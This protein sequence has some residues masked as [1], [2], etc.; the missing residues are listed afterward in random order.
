MI[1]VEHESIGQ[2]D[3]WYTP[4]YVFDALG[5]W[6]DTDVASPGA[7]IVPYIPAVIHIT[8]NSLDKNWFGRVWMNPPFGGQGAYQD[9]AEKFIE[10]GR[11]VA[12]CPSRTGTKWFVNFVSKADGVLFWSPRIKYYNPSKPNASSPGFASVLVAKGEQ[13]TRALKKL[14][15][16]HG[17]FFTPL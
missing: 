4:K 16:E 6:F 8:E 14:N 5:L 15:G 9:W 17:L 3:E 10:H 2:S 11:G 12:L 7:N 13:E 1:V